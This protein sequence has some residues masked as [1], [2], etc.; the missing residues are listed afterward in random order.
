MAELA[1]AG[2]ERV[3]V[4]RLEEGAESNYSIDTIRKVGALL[5]PGDELFS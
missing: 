4:S 1:C 2:M 5:G 3:E